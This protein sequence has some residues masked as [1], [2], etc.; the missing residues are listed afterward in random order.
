MQKYQAQAN[1]IAGLEKILSSLENKAQEVDER[2]ETDV[3]TIG[4]LKRG[5]TNLEAEQVPAII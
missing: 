2:L 3:A 5:L 4:E 1:K